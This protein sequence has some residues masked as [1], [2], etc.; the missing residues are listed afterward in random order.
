MRVLSFK[1]LVC[2]NGNFN[3]SQGYLRELREPLSVLCVK[4]LNKRRG[5][6]D[7]AENAEMN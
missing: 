2:F 7:Y 3:Y 1:S 4:N 5:R 6:K